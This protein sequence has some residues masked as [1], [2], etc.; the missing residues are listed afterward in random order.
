MGMGLI[1]TK[2]MTSST[3][4]SACPGATLGRALFLLDQRRLDGFRLDGEFHMSHDKVFY[5]E[6][7][8]VKKH[9]IFT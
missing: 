5:P 9:K 8:K 1:I 3:A 2:S 6:S 7:T 4:K